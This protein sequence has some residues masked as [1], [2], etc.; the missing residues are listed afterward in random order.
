MAVL[1]PS[2]NIGLS[3]YLR[4]YVTLIGKF[5]KST[6]E[7]ASD[8][9]QYQVGY[10]LASALNSSHCATCIQDLQHG[11]PVSVIGIFLSELNS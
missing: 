5:N 9:D 2:I 4:L 8:F 10:R 11:G 6:T 3:V 7:R 1:D